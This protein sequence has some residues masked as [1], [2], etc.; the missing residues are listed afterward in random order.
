MKQIYTL[1]FSGGHFLK[2]FDFI[3]LKPGISVYYTD[4]SESMR[5]TYGS[6]LGAGESLPRQIGTT[7]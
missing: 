6:G 1:N 3:D 7:E 4:T 2:V 5:L